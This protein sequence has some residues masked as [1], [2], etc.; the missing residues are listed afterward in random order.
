DGQ[1]TGAFGLPR[2]SSRLEAGLFGKGMGFRLSGIYTGKT[3]LDGSGLPGSRDLF[4]DDIATF[5]L[6]VFANMGEITGKNDGV[7]KDF[8]VSLIANNVFDAQRKVRDA[9]GDTPINY[10]PFV[11]DP[12]GLY[13]GIDLRKLF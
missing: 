5:N 6:R 13:L 12:L 11:I 1:A 4:F 3:R 10:Q 9:N 8:R 7:F 2:Q